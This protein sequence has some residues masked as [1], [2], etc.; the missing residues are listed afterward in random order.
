MKVGSKRRR[1]KQEIEDQKMEAIAKHQAI[2]DKLASYDQLKQELESFKQQAEENA[3]A[4]E[5][6][7]NMLLQGFVERDEDGGIIPGK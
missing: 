4:S 6:I 2:Q 3:E 5:V 7:E 1:T